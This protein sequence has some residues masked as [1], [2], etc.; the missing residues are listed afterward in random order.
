MYDL[1]PGDAPL[2]PRVAANLVES[3]RLLARHVPRGAIEEADGLL[4]I[5]TGIP[6]PYFNPAFVTRPLAD[7]AALADR[8]RRF[9]ARAGVP[10][11]LLATDARAAAHAA[12]LARAAALPPGDPLPELLLAPLPAAP[13]PGP[14]GLEI[15]VVGDAAALRA[16]NGALVPG[17]GLRA[18]FADAALLRVPDLTLYVGLLAGEPVAHALRVTSHRIA[19]IYNVG[20]LPTCRRRGA[21]R[22]HGRLP[23]QRLAAVGAGLRPL[24]AHGL[25]PRRRLPDLGYRRGARVTGVLAACPVR[26]RTWC[27]GVSAARAA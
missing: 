3:Y 20:T 23:G 14:A 24:P 17:G 19:G 27:S 10:G 2:L 9:Y 26:A 1:S 13:P 25:P 6:S 15:R 18:F 11:L 8:L 12:P 4:T 22:A 21:R 16:H 5:A 7:P